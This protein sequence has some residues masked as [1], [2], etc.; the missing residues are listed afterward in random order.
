MGERRLHGKNLRPGCSS[1]VALHQIAFR[2]QKLYFGM[3][4]DSVPKRSGYMRG[5]FESYD[6]LDKSASP[7]F[8]VRAFFPWVFVVLLNLI[9][10]ETLIPDGRSLLD[11]FSNL[12]ENIQVYAAL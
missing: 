5:L 8:V 12:R 1:Q 9:I 7:G 11:W 10:Y 2:S 3:E 6:R 4:M